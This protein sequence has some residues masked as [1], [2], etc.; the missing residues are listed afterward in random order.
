MQALNK[1]LL[2]VGDDFDRRLT[3]NTA[4]AAI[5]ELTNSVWKLMKQESGGYTEGD[6]HVVQ[7]A[8]EAIVLM[9]APITPHVCHAWWRALGHQTDVSSQ[10]WPAV[11]ESLLQT[12][13]V[14]IVVQVN[15]K[16][17]GHLQVGSDASKQELEQ[18]ALEEP[19]VMRFID[20]KTVRRVIVVPGKLVN[21]VI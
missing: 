10:A 6:A 19:N 20:G 16:L 11:D 15:G 9:L 21:V 1:A 12:D 18:L 4:L 3:F 8:L 17:R 14:D 5:R 13:S 2:K 7:K